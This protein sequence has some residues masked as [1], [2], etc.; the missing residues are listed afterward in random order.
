VEA[1][2]ELKTGRGAFNRYCREILGGK[3][4]ACG[5]VKKAV[6]RCLRDFER[7]KDNSFEYKFD[8]DISEKFYNF[9]KT[10]PL[11]D[12]EGFL[13]LMP[14]QVFCLFNLIGWV[15][16]QN[17]GKR[18]FRSGMIQV[19]RKNGKTTG[20]MY[21]LLIWD[22]IT[23]KSAESYF[24]EKDEP[25]ARKV[26]KEL[27]DVLSRHELLKDR[28]DSNVFAIYSGNKRMAY[29]TSES[30]GIDGYRPSMAVIDEY[31]CFP[32]DKPLT[33]MRYGGRSRDSSLAL[34]ITTAGTD[35]SLPCYDETLKAK[36][37]LNGVYEQDDYFCIIYG[38]DDDVK[39]D[40]KEA[41]VMANPSLKDREGRGIID[42]KL[43]EQDL[44]DSVNQ[45]SHKPDYLAKTLNVWTTGASSWIPVEKLRFPDGADF[46]LF[47]GKK[48]PCWGALDLSALNDWTAY[49][50]CFNKEDR[51]YF[52]HRFYIPYSTVDGRYRKENINILKWIDR[53]L[54]TVI[55]GETIDYTRILDD[56]KKDYE[57]FDIREIAY[58]N[59]G[60][61]HLVNDIADSMPNIDVFSFPQ[62]LKF[63]S[64]PTKE[65]EK[66]ILERKIETDCGEIITWMLGNVRIKPDPNGNYKPLKNYPS[67][68][69]RIDGVIT[70][71]MSLSRCLAN[72]NNGNASFEDVLKLF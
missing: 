61:R 46:S 26:Y 5:C 45:P 72:R 24:F 48:H 2:K 19:P 8:W 54:V 6:E 32:T 62:G 42:P 4:P 43:L 31:W 13:S 51:F 28:I 56:V 36:K 59:W 3:I 29:F 64:Q 55:N 70:M 49:T 9:S 18:R 60:S 38:V 14:W 68:S 11:P 25:Q 16:K 71:I 39:W 12:R 17:P 41:Y 67:S 23:S 57:V 20:L 65:L 35:I 21:P 69:G 34:I 22:F 66:R 15:Y 10:I 27:Q 30:I 33:A 47:G 52:K 37:V 58:D 50:L 53:G 40:S 7:I 1:V 63:M 44:R